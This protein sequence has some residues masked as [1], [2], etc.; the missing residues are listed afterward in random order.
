LLFGQPLKGMMQD[1]CA[2]PVIKVSIGLVANM[3]GDFPVPVFSSCKGIF[4]GLKKDSS[5]LNL[6]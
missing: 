3:T 6:H 5:D 4:Q 1:I 2:L